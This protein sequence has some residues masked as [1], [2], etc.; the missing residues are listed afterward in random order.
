MVQVGSSWR[1]AVLQEVVLV[2]MIVVQVIL[3][4]QAGRVI[5]LVFVIVV[6]L[7]RAGMVLVRVSVVAGTLVVL[8]GKVVRN[9]LVVVEVVVVSGVEVTV[10]VA[11]AVN[12]VVDGIPAM[13]SKTRAYAKSSP[14]ITIV[15]V[16][17]IIW[18]LKICWPDRLQFE[19][20]ATSS[21]LV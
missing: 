3:G 17:E 1:V 20:I 10:A 21:G 5:V 16:P 19:I 8:A 14:S 4:G 7:V 11:V 15:Q 9:M 13:R 6:V 18:L 2:L 12:V